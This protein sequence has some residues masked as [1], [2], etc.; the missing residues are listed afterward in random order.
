MRILERDTIIAKSRRPP[1]DTSP[2]GPLSAAFEGT[3]F[4]RRGMS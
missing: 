4:V 2:V 3:G 1:A